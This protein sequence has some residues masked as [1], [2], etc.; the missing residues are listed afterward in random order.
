MFILHFLLTKHFFIHSA[1]PSIIPL[2]NTASEFKPE[3]EINDPIQ[4]T[5]PRKRRVRNSSPECPEV[6]TPEGHWLKKYT[7]D[8]LKVAEKLYL[9]KVERERKFWPKSLFNN[10]TD[11]DQYVYRKNRSLTRVVPVKRVN[12][13]VS[14]KKIKSN[15]KLNKDNQKSITLIDNITYSDE[16]LP[17]LP[18]KTSK[19][20]LKTKSTARAVEPMAQFTLALKK[21]ETLT[22]NTKIVTTKNETNAPEI[23]NAPMDIVPESD[24]V[25]DRSRGKRTTKTS[26]KGPAVKRKK[27]TINNNKS[28]NN[29]KMG[30]L[31]NQIP[32]V[33]MSPILSPD[34]P[35]LA[36]HNVSFVY[37]IFFHLPL[38]YMF[39]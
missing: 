9:E 21:P 14:I 11:I 35:Q 36:A 22:R 5:P 30:Y 3:L 33:V 34:P 39:I 37:Q 20:T 27:L 32:K 15:D 16:G 19:F 17:A 29:T 2:T 1:I 38:I 13:S 23:C 7:M 12:V 25:E 24:P 10:S 28:E 18:P 4:C 6:V 8:R 26:Q 31:R